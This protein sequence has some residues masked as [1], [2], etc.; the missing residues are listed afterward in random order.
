MHSSW[1]APSSRASWAERS[2]AAC[3]TVLLERWLLLVL[4]SLSGGSGVAPPVLLCQPL[5][6]TGL[7]KED[8][9]QCP[10]PSSRG[11]AELTE[12]VPHH[13]PG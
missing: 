6:S 12:D 7:P 10:Y 2:P 5:S 8:A 1:R 11:A 9:A 4:R 13:I 3:T